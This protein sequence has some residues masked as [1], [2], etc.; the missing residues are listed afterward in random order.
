MN[1]LS[2]CNRRLWM[3]SNFFHHSVCLI[4]F[5]STNQEFRKRLGV[6]DLVI[7]CSLYLP[8]SIIMLRPDLRILYTC[9]IPMGKYLETRGKKKNEQELMW[10]YFKIASMCTQVK[11]FT[12]SRPSA[13]LINYS[14]HMISNY[15][16]KY[17]K[18]K[19]F[20]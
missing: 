16:T 19:L 7:R 11:H 3:V 6:Y 9:L 12:K 10:I 2:P 18:K 8:G 13:L 14:S 17:L 4:A 1:F 15:L 5:N 20:T